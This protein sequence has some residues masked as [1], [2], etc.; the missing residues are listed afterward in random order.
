M[1]LRDF[2]EHEPVYFK[3]D[4]QRNV[5]YY[6]RSFWVI[7]LFCEFYFCDEL[8]VM[9]VKVSHVIEPELMKNFESDNYSYKRRIKVQE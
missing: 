2:K 5:E 8:F 3:Y 7:N 6:Y 9:Y 1:L 4:L